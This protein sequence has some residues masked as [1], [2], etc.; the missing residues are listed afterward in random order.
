MSRGKRADRTVQWG[1]NVRLHRSLSG[2]LFTFPTL[3]TVYV[4]IDHRVV[5]VID[6]DV[7]KRIDDCFHVCASV[8]YPYNGVFQSDAQSQLIH[9]QADASATASS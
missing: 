9:T 4:H 8:C 6:A 5:N 3:I 7:N 1:G 2:I